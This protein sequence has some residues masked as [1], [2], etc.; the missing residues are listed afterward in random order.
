MA[1]VLKKYLIWALLGGALYGTMSYHFV[2]VGRSVKFL[3]KSELTLNYTFYS[4]NGKRNK[5]IMAIDEL[6]D[7]G[8]GEL[9]MDTGRMSEAEYNKFME[10]YAYE[11]EEDY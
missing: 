3:R 1:S 8:I 2:I 10:K 6:R 4:T 11:E 5:T 9:L 7:D